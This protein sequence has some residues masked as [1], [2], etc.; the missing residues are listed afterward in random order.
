MV[1]SILASRHQQSHIVL[2]FAFDK[3]NLCNNICV[4]DRNVYLCTCFGAL[5]QL[6]VAFFSR[7]SIN[8]YRSI[9]FLWLHLNSVCS[10]YILQSNQTEV[11]CSLCAWLIQSPWLRFNCIN[12][13][14]E[15][16]AHS[17][18]THNVLQIEFGHMFIQVSMA[19]FLIF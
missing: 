15:L 12:N 2:R 6:W 1:N 5:F 11:V 8:T 13:K 16:C 7:F 18:Y 10:N 19:I 4:C 17:Y 3:F 9:E 14:V